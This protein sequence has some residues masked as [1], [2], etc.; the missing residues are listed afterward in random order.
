MK[1]VKRS[2]PGAAG[3]RVKR[4]SSPGEGVVDSDADDSSLTKGGLGG[5]GN[6][7]DGSDDFPATQ[8][9]EDGFL[10][11]SQ[12][13]SQSLPGT[14]SQGHSQTTQQDGDE[15]KDGVGSTNGDAEGK[16]VTAFSQDSIPPGKDAAE[17][18]KSKRPLE[19]S[20]RVFQNVL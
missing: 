14:Q 19:V 6:S 13:Q 4:K 9:T 18:S 16:G 1:G 17:S 5:G 2:A 7:S 12:S 10:S 11:Q 3:G 8:N 20:C 15:D